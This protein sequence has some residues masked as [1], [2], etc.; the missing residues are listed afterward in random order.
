MDAAAVS[1]R[2][3]V[4]AGQLRGGAGT[5]APAAPEQQQR[6]PALARAACAASAAPQ[7]S[8]MFA[9][10]VIAI[11]GAAKVSR[12]TEWQ[13]RARAGA[14]KPLFSPKFAQ[15]LQPPRALLLHTRLLGR[16]TTP[17]PPQQGIG[18]AAA[19]MFADHGAAGLVLSDLDA[20]ALSATA[21]RARAAGAAVEEVAGDI[22]KDDV[23]AK[24]AAA[25]GKLGRLDVLVNNAGG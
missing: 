25:A 18:E 14:A 7:R 12:L 17:T 24:L 23:I 20:A 3:A 13:R 16:T 21:A 5:Q 15:R 9:G 1:R 6:Q 10:Q 11:T 4:L 22:T 2:V 8:S 19:L